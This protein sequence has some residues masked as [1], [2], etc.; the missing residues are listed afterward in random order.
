ME[1]DIELHRDWLTSI[2]TMADSL[3]DKIHSGAVHIT[4][5][6]NDVN[7]SFTSFE[8]QLQTKRKR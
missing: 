7:Q 6:R 2:D 5:L 3:R 8:E 4:P 1:K